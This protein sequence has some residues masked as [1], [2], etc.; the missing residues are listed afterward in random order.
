M[1]IAGILKDCPKG[2]KL[3]SLVCGE[4]EFVCVERIDLEY[5]ICVRST[6]TNSGYWFN[7]NETVDKVNE[8]ECLSF[9]TKKA[10]IGQHSSLKKS[11]NSS[12]LTKCWLGKVTIRFGK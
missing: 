9:H 10:E 6:T 5:K 2:T 11:I 4:C 8:G 1:N 12:H 3:Y 7:H